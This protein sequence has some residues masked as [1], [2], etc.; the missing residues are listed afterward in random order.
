LKGWVRPAFFLCLDPA[1]LDQMMQVSAIIVAAGSGARLGSSLPKAFVSLEGRAMLFY[2]LRTLAEV[3]LISELV[4][5]VPAG[6]ELAARGLVTEAGLKVPVK[7]VPGGK[8]RQDSVRIALAL[9]S[10]EAELAVVHDAA[11]P[12]ASAELFQQ[13]VERAQAHGAAI[14]A[15]PV[16]D[17]LKRAAQD[18]R[19][20]ETM[21]RAGLWQA[22]TPQ[23]FSRKLLLRAHEEAAH[24]RIT[25][26][27]DADLVQQ[28]GNAVEIVQGSPANLK[29]TTPDDLMLAEALAARL[30][31]R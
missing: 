13:C 15:I 27:D 18:L 1:K 14:A 10:A 20:T 31:P 9:T 12:F 4:L 22:Q 7:I 5:A 16:A 24:Q 3:S 11:R 2:S 17:T 21:A 6:M 28:L 23:A 30:F 8:E 26:T 19:I 25:A 29:I